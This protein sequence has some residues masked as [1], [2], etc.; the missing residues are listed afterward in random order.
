MAFDRK[1]YI[2]EYDYPLPDVRIAQYPLEQRDGSKLAVLRNGKISEDIFSNVA[3]YLPQNSL[4]LFNE[5]RVI[6][7]RLHFVKDTGARIEVFCLEPLAPVEIQQVFTA[8][9]Q[10]EWKC[11]VGN[12]KRWK[13]NESIK[14]EFLIGKEHAILKATIISRYADWF[15]I[16][17]EWEPSVLSF[18][19]VLEHAGKVPLPPYIH[20]DSTEADDARYQSIFARNEGSVAAPTASLHFTNAVIDSLKAK[21]IQSQKITLHVGAGTFKPVSTEVVIDH[22]MHS[23]KIIIPLSVIE[24]LYKNTDQ[25]KTLVGTTTVRSIESLYWQGLKWIEKKAASPELDVR[26]WDP[27]E[28]DFS[29]KISVKAS[30]EK[31]LETLDLFGVDALKGSTSL[32]I[33][34]GYE[35]RFAN[36]MITN[37]HQPKSTLLLL[38]AAFIGEQWKDIYR[39]ALEND[40]RFLSYGDSCLF[41]PSK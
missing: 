4:I 13:E 34:P 32:M 5:T 19:E 29:E 25:F 33:A 30:L 6:H 14:L 7:A 26:Q 8:R 12:A 16:R 24:Y 1:I 36:A 11:M 22:Q 41:I 37:F 2:S 38:V 27:Y 17:F 15:H 40:F 23:E 28:I 18:S 9:Q 21:N 35:Y 3:S 31:I 39:F 20:R 10:C